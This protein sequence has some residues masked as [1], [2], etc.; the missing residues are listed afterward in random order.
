MSG[1]TDARPSELRR[2]AAIGAFVCEVGVLVVAAT[3]IARSPGPVIGAIACVAVADWGIGEAVTHLGRRR[4]IGVGVVVLGVVGAVALL[5]GGDLF[6]ILVAAYVLAAAAAALTVIA[7]RIRGYTPPEDRTPPPKHAF[8][9]MNPW[10]GGGKVERF[11]LDEL[12]GS[13]GAKVVILEKGMDVPSVLRDAAARGADLLGAAGGDGTQ[14]LVAEVAAEHDLPMIVIPAGTRNHVALDLGLDRDDPRKALD[15][16]GPDGVE[17][18]IDLGRIG[19]RPFVNNVSLGAYAEI[20]RDPKYR[21]AKLQTVLSALPEVVGSEAS[22]GLGVRTPDGEEIRDPN[23]IQVGN[24]PYDHR[25]LKNAGRRPRMDTGEL[26]VDVVRFSGARELRKLMGDLQSGRSRVGGIHTWTTPSITVTGR[27]GEV[28]AG[29]DGEYL[30]FS[31]PL[32]IACRPSVLRIRVPAEREPPL[33]QK[34]R[35]ILETLRSLWSVAAG[36]EPDLAAA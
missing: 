14:A 25:S 4:A 18:R 31:S 13:K 30:T 33:T 35:G 7:L 9:L 19:D 29:V 12:A 11:Q 16:L 26:G 10:S 32:E 34:P 8:F 22:S 21:E 36:S 23:L 5:F 2:L 1:R 20:I 6:G 3:G 15:A 17:V 27:D 24:N 28:A